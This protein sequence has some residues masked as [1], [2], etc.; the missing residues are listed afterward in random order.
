MDHT[1]MD[2]LSSVP[3]SRSVKGPDQK[4]MISI[5]NQMDID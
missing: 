2:S 1:E 5:Y 3:F 4:P